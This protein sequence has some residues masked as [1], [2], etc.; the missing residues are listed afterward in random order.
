MSRVGVDQSC[1]EKKDFTCKEHVR[2]ENRACMLHVSS[3][4]FEFAG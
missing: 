2:Q 4:V 3:M 1:G